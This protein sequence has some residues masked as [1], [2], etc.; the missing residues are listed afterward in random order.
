MGLFD[1]FSKK[2][3]P[4]EMIEAAKDLENRNRT[5]C[6]SENHGVA[7]DFPQCND[8][9]A[10]NWEI[11]FV[12]NLNGEQSTQI[13]KTEKIYVEVG[14]MAMTIEEIFLPVILFRFNDDK[15]LS[16]ACIT[17]YDM[18]SGNSV[19][20]GLNYFDILLSQ[21]KINLHFIF[22]GGGGSSL[23]VTNRI[24][25][26]PQSFQMK[27]SV[28]QIINSLPKK[29]GHY[30]TFRVANARLRLEMIMYGKTRSSDKS[31]G[32]IFWERYENEE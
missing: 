10:K 12:I 5:Y 27:D 2:V 30:D 13:K 31:Y 28:N 20:C 26:S 8:S 15:S 7:R 21:E 23:S 6:S 1:L 17:A 11:A 22:Q 18:L 32:E 14:M 24:K 19:L 29:N 4:Q 25:L 9:D 16:F 3:T